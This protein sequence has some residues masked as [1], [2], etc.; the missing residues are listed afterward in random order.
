MARMWD[1]RFVVDDHLSEWN[2]DV[3]MIQSEGL[4]LIIVLADDKYPVTF[5][6]LVQDTR[7]QSVKT[8]ERDLI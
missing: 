5:A 4:R 8:L 1:P 6:V 3:P 2:S 7:L